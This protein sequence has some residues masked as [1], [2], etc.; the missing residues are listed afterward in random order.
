MY[1][2]HVLIQGILYILL[3]VT[4]VVLMTIYLTVTQLQPP[5]Y[6][7]N[8]DYSSALNVWDD[9][10]IDNAF[11]RKVVYSR[12]LASPIK[13]LDDVMSW[14]ASQS[15]NL[16]TTNFQNYYK[17]YDKASDAFTKE[18]WAQIREQL[19]SSGLFEAVIEKKLVSTAIVRRPPVLV[20]QGVLN[21]RWTW[22][23]QFEMTVNYE[24]A[25]ENRSVNYV[26][27]LRLVRVPVNFGINNSGLAIDSLVAK[28]L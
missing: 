12:S 22:Q 8:D 17:M 20:K 2:T 18:G 14:G 26:V 25:S 24:S 3:V 28:K 9:A 10:V 19:V 13:G 11:P 1:K 5:L 27:T 23:E 16:F 21:G 7:V 15:L 4:F 6:S